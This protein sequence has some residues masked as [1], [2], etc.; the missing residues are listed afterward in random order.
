MT[1]TQTT[2]TTGKA[3]KLYRG[4]ISGLTEYAVREDGALFARFQDRGPRGY[5]WGAWKPRGKVDPKNL[6]A[7][8]ESGFSCLYPA[9]PTYNP[10]DK[11]RLPMTPLP[12]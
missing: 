11:F 7:F 9:D 3:I 4:G 5:R 1:T 6:P 8:I 12:E 2:R 10:C